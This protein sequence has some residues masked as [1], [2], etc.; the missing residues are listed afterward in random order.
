MLLLSE[1]HM[2]GL[3]LYRD[4]CLM[5]ALKQNGPLVCQVGLKNRAAFGALSP[6]MS[7]WRPELFLA[8][9]NIMDHAMI[10]TA[11]VDEPER[12]MLQNS[13]GGKWGKQ[14]NLRQYSSQAEDHLDVQGVWTMWTI[15][16]LDLQ[17]SG[18]RV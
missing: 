8:D 14:V 3:C 1:S 16:S 17:Q 18:F 7:T 13:F 10:I 6:M 2:L 12:L 5:Q 4:E 11:V 15:K 9:P